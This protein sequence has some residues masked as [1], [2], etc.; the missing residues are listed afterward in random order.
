MTRVLVTG[1]AG[2]IGSHLCEALLNRGWSVACVDDLSTGSRSNVSYLEE[3]GDKRFHAVIEDLSTGEW[4]SKVGEGEFD[5]VF[6]LASAASPPDYLAM[7]LQ[8][9]LVGST[10]T[11]RAVEF[12]Y[13]RGARFIFT[14]TSEV[15]GDPLVHPQEE[16]YWGNVNPIGPRSVYDEGKRFSEALTIARYRELGQSVAIA[17]LFN[18]YGPRMRPGD[19]RVLSN[20]V[21]QALTGKP[22]TVYG[23]GSQTRSPCYV[24][25]LV[26]GLI[27]LSDSSLVGPVNLGNP[28]EVT[29][30]ELAHLV[31]EATG[32]SSTVEFMPLPED[33]P[34]RRRPDIGLAMRELKWSPSVTLRAGLAMF[35]EWMRARVDEG[36]T[37]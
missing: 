2:F 29:V 8:T 7:P 3:L 36:T 35:I 12:A 20:F 34:K 9:L 11:W 4:E 31:I 23:D 27:A 32:S 17:R 6:H 30:L 18:T 16:G 15:Y 1:G 10:G 5:L 21:E 19:G 25:D 22:L 26:R 28:H 33:D 24:S 37:V 13:Q 14:S